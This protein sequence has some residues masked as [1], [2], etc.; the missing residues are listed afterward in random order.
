MEIS[1]SLPPPPLHILIV[2]ILII[3]PNNAVWMLL[4]ATD[5]TY[6]GTTTHNYILVSSRH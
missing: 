2:H 5:P 4:L 3:K 1:E 6:A